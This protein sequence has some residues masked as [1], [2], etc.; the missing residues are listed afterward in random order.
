MIICFSQAFNRG[1]LMFV[2]NR[3]SIQV[4][5][6]FCECFSFGYGAGGEVGA[7]GEGMELVAITTQRIWSWW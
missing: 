3:G 6:A 2:M 5:S 4:W 1:E 7:G